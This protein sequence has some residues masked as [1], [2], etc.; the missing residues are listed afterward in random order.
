[1]ARPVTPLTKLAQD[2]PDALRS[3][4]NTLFTENKG[5]VAKV[6]L[7]CGSTT[8]ALRNV[9]KILGI[10]PVAFRPSGSAVAAWKGGA[11]PAALADLFEAATDAVIDVAADVADAIATVP[12]PTPAPV[13][14]RPVARP[15]RR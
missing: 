14:A 8:T 12:E 11:V 13:V 10:D 4:L 9:C 2:K 1:M 3:K 7:L 15:G 6:A 5:N